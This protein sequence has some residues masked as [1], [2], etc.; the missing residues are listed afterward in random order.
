MTEMQSQQT[1]TRENYHTSPVPG[2]VLDTS[3]V[4][5]LNLHSNSGRRDWRDCHYSRFR[6]KETEAKRGEVP[7]LGATEFFGDEA[8]LETQV[9]GSWFQGL[10]LDLLQQMGECIG[11]GE[12]GEDA[13]VGA[14]SFCT[15]LTALVSASLRMQAAFPRAARSSVSSGER[16]CWKP[17]LSTPGGM[18]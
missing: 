15:W 6:G 10:E 2:T 8:G 14:R 5:M 16:A 7:C 18:M 17:Q 4:D 1:S 11:R 13:G 9:T 3:C 12:T